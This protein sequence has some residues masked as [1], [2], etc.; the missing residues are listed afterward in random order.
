VIGKTLTFRNA[1]ESDADF[2]LSLRT[3]SNK[4]QY[5]SQV[6]S[7]FDAQLKWLKAYADLHDQAYFIIEHQSK[8]IGTIRLY[9]ALKNSFCW[10]S[11]ILKKESP[12]QAAI[13]S[14]LM[15]YEYG[16]GH[17]CFEMSHF[18]VRKE[19]QSV[20]KFHERFG[21]KRVREDSVNYYYELQGEKIEKAK[22]RY[23]DFLPNGI[24]I[25]HHL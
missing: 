5:R 3:D 18:E 25:S 22:H 7:D 6:S 2:I 1:V 19:N 8:P 24:K 13:E 20:C 11:W 21:A 10:G 17:L 4:S 12:R 9:D 15:V 16:I 14:A 23:I